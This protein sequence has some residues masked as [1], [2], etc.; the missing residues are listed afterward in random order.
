MRTC[1]RGHPHTGR[2]C[3][4]CAAGYARER[5]LVVRGTEEVGRWTD[6]PPR[7]AVDRT[8]WFWFCRTIVSRIEAARR[9]GVG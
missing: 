8:R 3:P 2:R 7:R 4:A 6:P 1:L 5:R 9:E